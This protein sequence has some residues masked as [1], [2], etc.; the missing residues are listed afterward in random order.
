MGPKASFGTHKVLEKE[1]K[2]NNK[3]NDFLMFD[4][5][6]KKKIK[7]DKFSHLEPIKY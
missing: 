3:E 2:N 7:Y 6:L 5:T 1:K 4:L